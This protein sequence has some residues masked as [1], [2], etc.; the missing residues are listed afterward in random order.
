MIIPRNLG[1]LRVPK[2]SYSSCS[3][4]L[5]TA[6]ARLK[7]A[8][9][10]RLMRAAGVLSLVVGTGTASTM[11]VDYLADR[12]KARIT[13]LAAASRPATATA[14]A[15]A[16]TRLTL[17]GF[18]DAGSF[19]RQFS[20]MMIEPAYAAPSEANGAPADAAAPAT[21][22]AG[23]AAPTA[24]VSAA[25]PM[26][27][28][29]VTPPAQDS[30]ATVTA[31]IPEANGEPMEPLA[32]TPAE[33]AVAPGAEPEAKRVKTVKIASAQAEPEETVAPIV[34]VLPAAS[35]LPGVEIGGKPAKRAAAKPKAA[36][37]TKVAAASS[38]KPGRA[39]VT[40]HVN[41]RTKPDSDSKVVTIVPS[42]AWVSVVRCDRW[43]EVSYA[44]KRG[45]IYKSF[46]DKS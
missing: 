45:Y 29:I 46:I 21:R 14:P 8:R 34:P 40:R 10:R 31:A 9:A 28:I 22:P 41:L 12:A 37:P 43:C 16:P 35:D 36:A 19:S 42:K 17:A 2:F 24:A 20:G 27:P 38:I 1:T 39:K 3:A 26:A 25:P 6:R 23:T 4:A 11:F 7:T 32:G 44:G 5:K 15:A 18:P 13:P 33:A 30:D